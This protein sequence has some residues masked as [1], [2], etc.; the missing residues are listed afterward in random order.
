MFAKPN[1]IFIN[2]LTSLQT[3]I[4]HSE[5]YKVLITSRVCF[6]ILRSSLEIFIL[7]RSQINNNMEHMYNVRIITV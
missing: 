7:S 1:D 2:F 3:G 5:F 6:V 4:S